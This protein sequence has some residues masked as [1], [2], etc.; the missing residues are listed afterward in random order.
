MNGDKR[1][2]QPSPVNKIPCIDLSECNLC[3]SCVAVCPSV[4]FINDT[5]MIEVAELDVYPEADVNEA[6]KYCPEDCIFWET[7]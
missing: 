1:S 7:D 3:E 6:I 2:A 4:F 5:G